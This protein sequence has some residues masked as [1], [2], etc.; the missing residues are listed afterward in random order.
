M[1]EINFIDKTADEVLREILAGLENGVK[2]PLY[3]GD[4]RRIFGEAL[5]LV[6]VAMYETVNDAARQKFLRYARGEVLDALAENYDISR[7]GAV[8]ATCSVRFAL[9]TAVGS[10]VTIPEGTRVTGDFERYFAVDTTAVIPAGDTDVTV[11]VTATEGGESYNAIPAGEINVLVDLLP[12]I[13]VVENT[14]ATAGGADGESDDALR[15]RIRAASDRSTTAGSAASYRYWAMQADPRIID[16]QV[17]TAES[18][19]RTTA[20]KQVLELKNPYAP[21]LSS[22]DRCVILTSETPLLS[23]RIETT[24]GVAGQVGQDYI[25][26]SEADINYNVYDVIVILTEGGTLYNESVLKVEFETRI[27]N[28]VRIIPVL[29]DG[30]IP[31]QTLLDK[32][33]AAV[34]AENVRPMTDVV[35][36]AAPEQVSYDIE[37]EYFVAAA[38]DV[39]SVVNAIEGEGGAIDQYIAWQRGALDRDINPD[40]LR[41]LVLNAGADRVNVVAPVYTQLDSNEVARFSGDKTVTHNV[42]G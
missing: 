11:G 19:I 13:D 41:Q 36:V 5:A 18:T 3:P 32:V 39:S 42:E 34:S 7:I 38:A 35:T 14:T 21:S 40:K 12:Y 2:E 20:K 33:L 29:E 37:I 15:E 27:S 8:P 26:A 28:G 6:F 1:S 16:A 25:F 22:S 17:I 23:V 4:E 31:D 30:E 10:D 24:G 9:N